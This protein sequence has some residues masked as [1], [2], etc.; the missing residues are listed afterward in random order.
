MKRRIAVCLGVE[1]IGE[2]RYDRQGQRERAAFAYRA[3]WLADPARFTIDPALPLVSGFQFHARRGDGSPFHG[4]I[5]DTEPDGWGRRVILRDHARRRATARC[6]GVTRSPPMLGELDFLLAVDDESRVGALRFRD[7]D[8]VFQGTADELGRAPPL[9]AIGNLLAASHAIEHN[10]ETERDLAYLRGRG[11]S[12][13]GLRPNA[14][15]ATPTATWRSA[16]S[17]ASPTNARSPRARCSR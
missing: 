14:R 1:P 6:D 11:T 10:T 15:S 4:A 16:S 12:L 8:G 17:P 13:G 3:D 7:E 9:V 2:L 5:A